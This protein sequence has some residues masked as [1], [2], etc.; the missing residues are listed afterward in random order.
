MAINIMPRFSGDFCGEAPAA[1]IHAF[2]LETNNQA[3]MD[4]KSLIKTRINF[5]F[6]LS[7]IP[8]LN[9]EH[10]LSPWHDHLI[11]G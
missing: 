3:T 11:A 4:N 2:Q 8:G 10:V 9:Q 1:M 7:R 6:Y 5:G